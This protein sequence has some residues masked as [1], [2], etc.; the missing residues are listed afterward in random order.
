MLL[1]SSGE[2]I[3]GEMPSYQNHKNY[4]AHFFSCQKKDRVDLLLS[5]EKSWSGAGLG[6]SLAPQSFCESPAFA[7]MFVV[8][9]IGVT[10]PVLQLPRQLFRV[11]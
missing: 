11:L 6:L 3:A 5:V 2:E 8:C 4:Q 1:I 10:P 7:Y 9:F